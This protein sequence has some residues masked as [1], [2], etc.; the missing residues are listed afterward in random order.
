MRSSVLILLLASF[1]LASCGTVRESRFN[2]VNWF[3]SSTSSS[4][5]VETT[6]TASG[7]VVPVNPLI[8]NKKVSQITNVTNRS[9]NAL[10]RARLLRESDEGPY[11]G[12]LVDQVTSLEIK[13]TTTGA[14]VT[15]N[16]VTTRQ[17]AYDVRL[18]VANNGAPVDGVLTYE[19]RAL[20]PIQTLQGP[21]RTR[22]IQAAAPLSVQELEGIRT[23]QVVAR[24]NTRTSRR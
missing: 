22:R 18:V 11:E 10:E 20:Q 6:V 19:L 14:I 21:E 7:E 5:E 24:R 23:V 12:T 15:A 3:G 8:G 2:P 9:T 16:G 13:R 4:N 1:A 17:G